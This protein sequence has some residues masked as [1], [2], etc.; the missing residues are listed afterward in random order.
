MT[1]SQAISI[2]RPRSTARPMSM[3]LSLLSSDVIAL[4]I[5]VAISIGVKALVDHQVH[6]SSYIRLAPLLLVFLSIYAM[7]GLYSGVAMG[8]P[9]EIRRATISSSG[10][11]LLLAAM[12]VSWRGAAQVFTWTFF[13]AL[14][15]SVVLVPLSRGAVRLLLSRRE[16]WG[17]PTVVIG[18][19]ETGRMALRAIH[20]QPGLGLKPIAVVDPNSFAR[21]LYGVPVY[22]SMNTISSLVSKESAA[23]AIVAMPENMSGDFM[24]FIE[25][26]VVPHFAHVLVIPSLFS[27]SHLWMRPK[28]L[29]NM[30]GLE[31]PQTSRSGHEFFKRLLD[32]VVSGGLMLFLAPLFVGVALA[33]KVDSPGP[34][35][36]GHRRIGRRGSFFQAWKFRTMLVHGDEILKR[37]LSD[38]EEARAEWER[39]HKLKNDPRVTRVGRLLRKTSLDELPQLWNV[40]KNE[41]SLVGPRPIVQAEVSRYGAS[42]SEYTRVKGGLTGLWQVSGRND[43]TYDERVRLDTMYVRNRSVWLDLFILYRTVGVVLFGSGAY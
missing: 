37:H 33:I 27:W 42:F 36:F 3:I 22:R 6:I 11:F 31:M 38:N 7:M 26:N 23:Y 14:V 34:A 1:A 39:D 5:S 19:G 32:V 15:L 10:L 20:Q 4:L 41:M 9:E 35:L 21:E 18:A 29:G 30:L 28:S 43:T 16:W 17:Y 13:L 8:P 12:T 2:D 25:Q 24:R 40:L